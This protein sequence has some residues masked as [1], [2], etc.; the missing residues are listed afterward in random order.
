LKLHY[1]FRVHLA[2]FAVFLALA[3]FGLA[4]GPDRANA[5]VHQTAPGT[6]MTIAMW[7]WLLSWFL[8]LVF[9]W[10]MLARSW[11]LRTSGENTKL[12]LILFFFQ[13][14]RRLLFLLETLRDRS[15]A[16]VN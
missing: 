12:F 4:V 13:F 9:S 2:V 11:H 14:S 10:V 3:I 7:I 5:V 6:L 16:R 15:A 8:L 1:I